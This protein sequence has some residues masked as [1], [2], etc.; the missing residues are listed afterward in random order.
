[1]SIVR[2][3]TYVRPDTS[4][5]FHRNS[6]ASVINIV[7]SN[8]QSLKD[9]GALTITAV[10]SDDNI[11][12]T[13]TQTVT[14]L[15]TLSSLDTAASIA[16]DADFLAYTTTHGQARI[17]NPTVTGIG[18]AFTVTYTYTF[19][20]AGLASHDSLSALVSSYA[21]SKPS[22]VSSNSIEDTVINIV[23][24]FTNEADYTTN[25]FN[26]FTLVTELNTD[27]VTRAITW[28]AAGSDA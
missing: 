24:T 8:I 13:Y 2:T 3:R 4:V 26:D 20:T 9:S 19:A 21:T 14:D 28:A 25:H 6:G 17:G 23:T 11:S 10:T 5:P 16:L 12:L 15:A 18:S 7:N 22:N 27:G 1:M